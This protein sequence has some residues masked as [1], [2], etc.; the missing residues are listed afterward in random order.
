MTA[1]RP[2]EPSTSGHYFDESVDVDSDPVVVDVTL[3]DTAFVMETDRGVFSRGHLDTGTA[4]LVRSEAPLASSGD[5][6]DLGCGAGPIALTMARR[7]PDATVWAVDVN[8]RARRL[9]VANAERNRITNIRVAAPDDVPSDIRFE[10]IWSNPPVRIGKGAM[11]G[12]VSD[13]LG[14]LTPTGTA[15]MVVQKHL[16]ADSL[17]RWLTEHGH[18]V[19]RIASKSGFRLLLVRNDQSN[20]S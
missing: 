18:H 16:G 20:P 9:T 15:T 19:E 11:R 10:T 2:A 4:L 12:L 14:R 7:C 3:P 5:L 1:D 13:W 8:E 6:L 17:H